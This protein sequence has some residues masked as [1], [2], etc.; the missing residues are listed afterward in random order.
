MRPVI[1]KYAFKNKKFLFLN[2]VRY[3][4]DIPFDYDNVEIAQQI[5]KTIPRQVVLSTVGAFTG[6]KLLDVYYAIPLDERE[7]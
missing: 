5:L 4:E 1:R 2:L 3:F 7:S 6:T